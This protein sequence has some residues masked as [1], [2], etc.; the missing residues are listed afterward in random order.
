[1]SVWTKQTKS[2]SK[3]TAVSHNGVRALAVLPT[4]STETQEGVGVRYVHVHMLA[5]SNS[6]MRANN[7]HAAFLLTSR[8]ERPGNKHERKQD[9]PLTTQHIHTHTHALPKQNQDKAE[10]TPLQVQQPTQSLPWGSTHLDGYSKSTFLSSTAPRQTSGFSPASAAS[11]AAIASGP[12]RIP[13]SAGGGVPVGVAPFGSRLMS[14]K[15]LSAAPTAC[16]L[17]MA[18]RV[19]G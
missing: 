18:E 16:V 9:T 3:S 15:T 8:N 11:A 12:D 17:L 4:S 5:A 14:S 7:N 1:M 10:K 13:M 6:K 19:R 2:K